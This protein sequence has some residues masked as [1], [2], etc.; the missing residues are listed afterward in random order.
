MRVF[1]GIVFGYLFFELLWRLLFAVTNTDPHAPASITFETGAIA[2]GLIFAVTSGF[3]ASFIG[4]K[5][6]FTAAKVAG[7]LVALTAI[8]VMI[9]KGP[10]WPQVAALLFMSP[11]IVIGGYTYVL[12]RRTQTNSENK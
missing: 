11:G 6:H 12:R 8:A 2:F 3:L 4:G 1:S 9:H 7:A 10:A 5:P